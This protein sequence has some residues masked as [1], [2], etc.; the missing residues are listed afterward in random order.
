M[1]YLISKGAKIN[2][3]DKYDLSALHHAAMRGNVSAIKILL[4]ADRICKEV[5][6][7]YLDKISLHPEKTNLFF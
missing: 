5:I 6:L 7:K 4:E 2:A 1:N 3:T